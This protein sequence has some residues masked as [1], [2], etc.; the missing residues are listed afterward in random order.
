MTDT[1]TSDDDAFVLMMTVFGSL[2]AIAAAAGAIL[3]SAESAAVQWLLSHHVLV[4]ADAGPVLTLPNAGGAGLD[5]PRLAIAAA[6][7]LALL[8][9]LVSAARRVRAR[10]GLGE[11]R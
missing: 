3:S 8:Y 11:P 1:H 7:V 2:G 5:E 4:P 9:L 6:A 10:S